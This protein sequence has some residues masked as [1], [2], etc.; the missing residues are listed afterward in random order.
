MAQRPLF[1]L[2]R[3]DGAE[4]GAEALQPGRET[5]QVGA[6]LVV[7]EHRRDRRHQA[8]RGGEQRLGDAGR[9]HRQVGVVHPRDRR[10]AVHDPPHGAEQPDEGRSGADRGE[11]DGPTLQPVH[12]PLHRY[13]DCAVHPLAA[14]RRGRRRRR[15][16]P[17]GRSGAIRPSPRRT[18]RP[19][20]AP[21]G[22]LPGRTGHRD[23]HRTRTGPRRHRPA[24]SP[25]AG[26]TISRTPPPRPR[27]W[28]A[29][30]R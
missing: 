10:E 30:G 20:D 6:D 7:G 28:R 24:C 12:L 4:L 23:C 1:A 27:H 15:R 14:P 5:G 29:A 11:E 18:P 8:D 3:Q 25:G 16:R 2:A 17:P 26:S 19:S 21:A 13:G 9:D 22:R